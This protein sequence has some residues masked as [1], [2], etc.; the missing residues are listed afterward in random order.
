[1]HLQHACVVCLNI[2]TPPQVEILHQAIVEQSPNKEV[3]NFTEINKAF[4][5]TCLLNRLTSS[6]HPYQIVVHGF[7]EFQMPL[8][9]HPERG[10]AAGK[11][12][13]I[14]QYLVTTLRKTLVS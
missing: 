10:I 13:K 14:D 4:A 7:Y 9:Q 5:K 8:S 11:Q 3:D 1:L 2:N 6:R 12:R